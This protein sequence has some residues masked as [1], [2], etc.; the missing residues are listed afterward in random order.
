MRWIGM[1]TTRR[2]KMIILA[3]GLGTRMRESMGSRPKILADLGGET[4]LDRLLD[5]GRELRLDPVIVTRPE[6]AADLRH[7]PAE[8]LVEE[9][10]VDLLTT[11]FQT[12]GALAEVREAGE[13]FVWV[14]GDMVFSDTRPLRELVEGHRPEDFA[15]FLVCRTDRFK[16]KIRF[17]PELEF[18]VTREGEWTL[19][20]PP[21]VVQSSRIFSW[22]DRSPQPV[23]PLLPALAAGE[24]VAFRDCFPE[25]FEID[26]PFDL[27]AARAH[28]ARGKHCASIS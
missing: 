9:R 18:A 20:L 24:T 10:P 13:P 19:S 14:G 28:L 12:R 7:A 6:F 11:L 27:A 8:V 15:S 21:F 22:L 3:A 17:E 25:V 26:T 2:M 1:E 16:A 4:I 5:I 23:Y